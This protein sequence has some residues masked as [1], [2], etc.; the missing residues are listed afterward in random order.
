MSAE[1]KRRYDQQVA[2]QIEWLKHNGM[3]I[4]IPL[5]R[6]PYFTKKSRI[7]QRKDA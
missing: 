7:V 2:K 6:S 5:R 3:Q 4:H 1:Q